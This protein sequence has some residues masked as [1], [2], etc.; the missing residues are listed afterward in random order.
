MSSQIL[1]FICIN[2]LTT[3]GLLFIYDYV[4]G[5]LISSFQDKHIEYLYK[6]VCRL[7]QQVLDIHELLDKSQINETNH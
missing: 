5:K 1:G 7:E 4:S 3:I 2:S 6:K